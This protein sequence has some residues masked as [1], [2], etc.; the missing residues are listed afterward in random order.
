MLSAGSRRG[1]KTRADALTPSP[2]HRIP[3]LRLS[4]RT[5]IILNKPSTAQLTIRNPRFPA[6]GI[7]AS[8]HHHI[9][10]LWAGERGAPTGVRGPPARSK[11]CPERV[12]GEMLWEM[13]FLPD[14]TAAPRA[15]LSARRGA[16]SWQRS[17]PRKGARTRAMMD[18]RLA[19]GASI[20]RN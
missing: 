1:D 12:R 14:P 3:P 5:L 20:T 8:S 16:D 11:G 10:A 13:G 9:P 17:S 4:R 6:R 2:P 7:G 19:G 18:A 15:A